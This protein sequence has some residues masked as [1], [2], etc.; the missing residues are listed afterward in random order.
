MLLVIISGGI[1]ISRRQ[2][3]LTAIEVI[4]TMPDTSMEEAAS[5]MVAN[6]V[7]GLP[8]VDGKGKAAVKPKACVRRGDGLGH[9]S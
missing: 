1:P 9:L 4:T 2:G 8:V 7:G 5:L 3:G 6:R